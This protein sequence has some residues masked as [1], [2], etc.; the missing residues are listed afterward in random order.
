MTHSKNIQ[1]LCEKIKINPL[2]LQDIVSKVRNEA[3]LKGLDLNQIDFSKIS[4]DVRANLNATL[5]GAESYNTTDDMI[6][7]IVKQVFTQGGVDLLGRKHRI[8]LMEKDFYQGINIYEVARLLVKA[9]KFG[10]KILC[11]LPKSEG[12]NY[13]YFVI[14]KVVL[15]EL[16]R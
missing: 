5:Y 12:V 1:N 13:P 6:F 10:L 9:D 2:R 3:V 4:H 16:N 11:C 15:N 7:D 14:R 8:W